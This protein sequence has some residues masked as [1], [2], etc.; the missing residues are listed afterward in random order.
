M[1]TQVDRG[2][3]QIALTGSIYSTLAITVERYLTVCHPFYT[4]SHRWTAKHYV[5]PIVAFSFLY[6]IP[7]FFELYTNVTTN[8]DNVTSATSIEPTSLRVNDYY[9]QVLEK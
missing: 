7:K 8:D 4:V 3:F 1:R 9:I 2:F 5:A 6:N